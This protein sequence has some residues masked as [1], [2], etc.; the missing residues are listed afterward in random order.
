MIVETGSHY[1]IL[2]KLGGRGMGD[3]VPMEI[4]QVLELGGRLLMRWMQRMPNE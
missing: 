2:N 1:G 3:G 4:D